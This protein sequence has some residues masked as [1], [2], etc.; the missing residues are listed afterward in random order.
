MIVKVRFLTPRI[1][2]A[3]LSI[4]NSWQCFAV[5]SCYLA[6]WTQTN[7]SRDTS[8]YKTDKYCSYCCSL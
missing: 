1:I 8:V 6:V 7:T 4:T 3:N 5:T 2:R